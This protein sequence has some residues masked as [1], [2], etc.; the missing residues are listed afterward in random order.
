[1]L[2]IIAGAVKYGDGGDSSGGPLV[3]VAICNLQVNNH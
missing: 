1:M 3:V 2:V